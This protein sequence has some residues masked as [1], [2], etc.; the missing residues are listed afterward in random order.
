LTPAYQLL[1]AW[2]LLL[3]LAAVSCSPEKPSKR[4]SGPVFRDVAAE[5]GLKH[6][7][8][9]GSTGQYYLPEIMGSGAALIDFDNDGDLD[10]LLV[11]TMVLQPGV[12]PSESKFPPI[13][14]RKPGNRLFRNELIPS[15]RLSFTD[16]SDHAGISKESYG[17]GVAVG[18]Y[19][20][21]SDPDLYITAFGSNTLYRNNGDGTFAD[22]TRESGVEAPGW[23][24]SATFFDY[25]NDGNLDLYV[26]SYLD[27]TV[28]GNKECHNGAGDR[29]YCHPSAYKPLTHR[30]FRN[31]GNGKFSDVTQASGIATLAGPGLGVASLDYDG[32][33]WMDLYVANDGAANFLWRNLGSGRLSETALSAGAAYAGDGAPRAG[34]GIAL[35]DFD[36]DGL[37]DVLVTNLIREGATLFR[38]RAPGQFYDATLES[39]LNSITAPFTGFGV[40]AVDFD[41]DGWL[42]LFIANGSVTSI[43]ELRGRPYPYGQRNLVVR[44]TG[45]SFEDVTTGSGA[46]SQFRD[47]GRG[48][49]FGDIDNDGDIDIVV[50]NNNGPVRLLLN[51]TPVRGH[52]LAVRLRASS[53]N[54]DAFGA[55][56]AVV[57]AGSKPLWRRVQT[58][59][60][61]LSASDMRVH[62]GLGDNP[63]GLA[64]VVH[65]P[66][67]EKER[68]KGVRPDA[69]ITLRQGDGV[70]P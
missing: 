34:M 51:E 56:V 48:A 62:F 31:L 58:D 38:S 45:Q 50:T 23:S 35:G 9:I 46:V 2:P 3:S 55:R 43:D 47:V 59:G 16:I 28:R 44:N 68:W 33:G 5:V 39:G 24:T 11:Q 49:A 54:R 15:G 10:V 36:R 17:M 26:A 57:S 8:F 1:P 41:N 63:G 21:D 14:G 29:D 66:D 52:W 32:D 60:S 6:S 40:R 30:L 13:R 69:L 27:F 64:V 37:E 12:E 70:K 67:G 4:H 22:V 53:R 25:N 42:D 61:Y 20:S 18:D 19:D 65:W 7:H